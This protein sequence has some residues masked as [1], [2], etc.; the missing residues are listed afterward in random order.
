MRYRTVICRSWIAVL[1]AAMCFCQS[2]LASIESNLVMNPGAEDGQ[3]ELPS[4][5]FA[6]QVPA[7]GLRM[8]RDTAQ[9]Y[10]GKA[11]LAIS[12]QHDYPES[13]SNNWA[14]SLQ[15]T[16]RS[17]T[18]QLTAWIRAENADAV[19]VCL[20]CWDLKSEKMLAFGGTPI[21][22][23]NQD[24][25]MFTSGPISVPDGTAMI[26]VRAALTGKGT[27]WFDDIIVSEI[28]TTAASTVRRDVRPTV[29][30]ASASDDLLA[31]QV[32]GQI[33]ATLPV[34]KDC[35]VLSYMPDW[36]FGNIDNFAIANNDGGVR[37]FFNWQQITPEQLGGANRQFFLAV[38]SRKTTFTEPGGKVQAFEILKDWPERTSWKTQPAGAT[39]PAA[40]FDLVP[41]EGWKLF[42]VT[43]I[44]RA[45]AQEHRIGHGVLLR[46]D[47]E[48]AATGAKQN[49]SGYQFVSREGEGEW[50]ELRPRLL[51]VNAF[52][53]VVP[54]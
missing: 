52:G 21:I 9:P 16:P 26:L 10:T 32:P 54:G 12:N 44:V 42:D 2:A 29:R 46:F 43:A 37:A 22:R 17:K 33:V 48:N 27:A 20:Q 45:Q 8:W 18:L 24:W 14:Q 41:E 50:T 7:E 49:W 51:I 5:W 15:V 13:V 31:G 40:S 28:T 39:E 36:A 53:G 1:L 30:F 38:Y 11:A 34:I 6:A 25:H 4:I 3:G 47:D 23:G 35:M 19:N